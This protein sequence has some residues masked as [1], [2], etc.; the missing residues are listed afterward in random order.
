MQGIGET[1][2]RYRAA[3]ADVG[4]RVVGGLPGSGYRIVPDRASQWVV[5][6]QVFVIV[7]PS[8]PLPAKDN[9]LADADVFNDHRIED[10][11]GGSDGPDFQ[12]IPP[13]RGTVRSPGILTRRVDLAELRPV[14]W[15][16]DST[17]LEGPCGLPVSRGPA[18]SRFRESARVQHLASG[19]QVRGRARWWVGSQSVE[20][21]AVPPDC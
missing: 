5:E 16:D 12:S 1:Q 13:A 14:L 4:E 6:F 21:P 10:F 11:S 18:R 3:I 7:S 2:G 9:Y 20:R 8:V 15:R 17:L 19:L